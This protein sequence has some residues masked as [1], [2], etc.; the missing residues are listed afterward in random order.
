MNVPGDSP[1]YFGYISPKNIVTRHPEVARTTV[2]L[3]CKNLKEHGAAYPILHAEPPP[4]GRRQLITPAI[5][6]DI[7]ELLMRAPTHYLDEIQHWILMN[8]N[9]WVLESTVCY[10]IKCKDFTQKVT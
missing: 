1:D 7:V 5:E 10:T 3:I 2:Y 9:I 8:H 4:I 6:N